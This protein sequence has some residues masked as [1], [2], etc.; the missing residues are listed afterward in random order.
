MSQEKW[1]A[2]TDYKNNEYNGK[3][4]V[5]CWGRVRNAGTQKILKTFTKAEGS[6]YQKV[7]IYDTAGN[8]HNLYVHQLVA[9]HF[10]GQNTEGLDVDHIDG[11]AENNSYTNLRY[12]THQENVQAA[13]DARQAV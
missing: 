10:I 9:F 11:N 3:Y 13:Y 12:I 1:T 5:S 7:R 4:E 8:A 2:I 6:R